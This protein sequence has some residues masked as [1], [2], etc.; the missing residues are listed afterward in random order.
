MYSK[1]AIKK[2]ELTNEVGNSAWKKKY[3]PWQF[4]PIRKHCLAHTMTQV[5]Y[6]T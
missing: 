2:E 6:T 4:C 3:I 5:L 1:S